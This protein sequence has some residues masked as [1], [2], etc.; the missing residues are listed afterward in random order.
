LVKVKICGFTR[1][2]DVKI[3]CKLGAD[4]VGAIMV[5]KSP[6][7][8]S[9]D[10]AKQILAAADKGVEKVAVIMPQSLADIEKISK[11]LKPDYLQLH[12]KFPA[13][14]IRDVKKSLDARLIVVV[15][16]P[17]QVENRQRIIDMAKEADKVADLTLLD[18]KGLHGGGTGLTHDWNLSREIRAIVKKP[19]LLAGG[20]NPSNVGQAIKTVHPYG[21]D[22]ATGVESSIGIKSPALIEEFMKAV[23][24]ASHG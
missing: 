22:V 3:A 6:R 24:E 10:R 20:L 4:M 13:S 9:I 21:V 17:Q 15:P 1:P 23:K 8:V 5:P 11:E 2:E 19:L 18:T 7:N 12:L 14:D 16:I